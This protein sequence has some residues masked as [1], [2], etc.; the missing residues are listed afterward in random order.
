MPTYYQILQ[1]PPTATSAEIEAAYTIR[2]KQWLSLSTHP[3]PV[4]VDKATQALQWLEKIRITLTDQA[5]RRVYDMSIGL[6]GPESGLTDPQIIVQTVHAPISPPQ[7]VGQIQSN[8]K[9]QQS[10]FWVCLNCHTTNL[11]GTKN[12]LK[13]GH[14]L[15][16]ECP[17]CGNMVELDAKFC[18]GCGL[19]LEGQVKPLKLKT[20]L[21][22][23]DQKLASKIFDIR[24]NFYKSQRD[25][26]NLIVTPQ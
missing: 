9:S 19:K 6:N 26:L 23:I 20:E 7:S 5:R 10:N 25:L 11:I 15:G 8:V 2:Y 4:M 16:Y 24:R 1:L 3:D 18:R 12:C 14:A 22:V 17:R 21:K 13:C